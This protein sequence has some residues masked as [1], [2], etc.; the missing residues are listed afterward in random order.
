MLLEVYSA[1]F[2]PQDYPRRI[3]DRYPLPEGNPVFG[4]TSILSDEMGRNSREV[5][6]KAVAAVNGSPLSLTPVRAR[7]TP[8]KGFSSDLPTPLSS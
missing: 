7:V 6:Y 4:R 3:H 1:P 8:W 5:Q 2:E